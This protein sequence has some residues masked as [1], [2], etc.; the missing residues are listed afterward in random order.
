MASDMAKKINLKEALFNKIWIF[1][2]CNFSSYKKREYL[3][4]NNVISQMAKIVTKK[5]ALIDKK[6]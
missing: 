3:C 4:G 6:W 5:E 2:S 1:R